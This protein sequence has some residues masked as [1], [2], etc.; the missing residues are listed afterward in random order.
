[1]IFCFL[2]RALGTIDQP[3]EDKESRRGW[4]SA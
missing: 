4:V 3:K 1:M 2:Y